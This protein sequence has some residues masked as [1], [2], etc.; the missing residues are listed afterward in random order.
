M[1]QFSVVPL[2]IIMWHFVLIYFNTARR[3]ITICVIHDF[4]M[5]QLVILCCICHFCS[6][7]EP[8]FDNFTQSEFEVYSIEYTRSNFVFVD[9]IPYPASNYTIMSLL[10]ETEY[11]V[12]VAL[13]NSAGLG[14]YSSPVL[15][16][17]TGPCE[18]IRNFTF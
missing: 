9:Y 1:K 4:H 18:S 2:V 15:M 16:N 8:S 14:E 13:N 11:S 10:L 6:P 7:K 17:T 3:L 5:K 12:R